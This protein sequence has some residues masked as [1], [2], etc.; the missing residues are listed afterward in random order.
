MSRRR[1]SAVYR[2]GLLGLWCLFAVFP[3]YWMAVT[4]FT[5]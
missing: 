3:I 5:G 2:Y 4:A 1:V